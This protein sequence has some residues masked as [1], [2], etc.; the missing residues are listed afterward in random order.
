MSIVYSSIFELQKTNYSFDYSTKGFD[1]LKIHAHWMNN[2]YVIDMQTFFFYYE[3]Y[4]ETES[5]KV[6]LPEEIVIDLFNK[7]I[8]KEKTF[9]KFKYAMNKAA[10]RESEVESDWLPIENK[11]QFFVL[12]NVLKMLKYSECL[13]E[14]VFLRVFS[15]REWKYCPLST[16][17]IVND[18]QINIYS[19]SNVSKPLIVMNYNVFFKSWMFRRTSKVSETNNLEIV[20]SNGYLSMNYVDDVET[21]INMIHDEY[22]MSDTIVRHEMFQFDT[23]YVMY[24]V[25]YK[26]WK[27]RIELLPAITGTQPQHTF[28]KND[29][30]YRD[31]IEPIRSDLYTV[32]TKKTTTI[33]K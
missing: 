33:P 29:L 7:Y 19:D 12:A 8:L 27:T 10:N 15:F 31:R 24:A 26:K 23:Y 9:A 20:I 32:T 11:T 25:D 3:R 13:N 30:K 6:I 21:V 1:I 14:A 5:Y 2:Y 4:N 22:T 17:K 18:G 16:L 28:N